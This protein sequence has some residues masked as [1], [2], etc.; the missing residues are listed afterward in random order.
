MYTLSTDKK[1]AVLSGL[2]E[3][4][5]LRSMQAVT[6]GGSRRTS[7]HNSRGN[8]TPSDGGFSQWASN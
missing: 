2:V 7:D 3:G 6:R 8:G 5:S 1:L 4:N